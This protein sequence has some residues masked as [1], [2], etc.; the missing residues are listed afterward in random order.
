MK[1][2]TL[3]VLVVVVAGLLAAGAVAAGTSECASKNAHFVPT[4][5]GFVCVRDL[6]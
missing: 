3:I 5:M 4:W 1:L 6:P 2:E